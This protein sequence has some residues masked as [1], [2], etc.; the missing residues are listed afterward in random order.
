MKDTE[1][2]DKAIKKAQLADWDEWKLQYARVFRDADALMVELLIGV[3]V[4]PV[5]V[6]YERIIFSPKFAECFWGMDTW[7]FVVHIDQAPGMDNTVVG[8]K[9]EKEL[10]A[11]VTEWEYYENIPAYEYHLQQ[12]VLEDSQDARVAYLEGFL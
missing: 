6:S 1:V 5:I 3:D 8:W 12:L 7:Y 9:S 2:I 11:S 4:P 10:Q